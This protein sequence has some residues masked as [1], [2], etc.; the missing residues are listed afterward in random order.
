MPTIHLSARQARAYKH[1]ATV[2]RWSSA[3]V[4]VA[5]NVRCFAWTDTQNAPTRGADNELLERLG[6]DKII[7]HSDYT[8][9]PEYVF[10]MTD[11]GSRTGFYYAARLQAL[12]DEAPF[13][14]Q[15]WVVE[16]LYGSDATR[17]Q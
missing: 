16:R 13:R 6:E 17:W 12:N 1:T 8:I 7:L 3:R 14:E 15:L 2:Y 4:T 11:A 9:A 5:G 10:Y